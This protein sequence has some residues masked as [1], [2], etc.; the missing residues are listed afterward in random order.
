MSLTRCL[1][2]LAGLVLAG[3]GSAEQPLAPPPTVS[4]PPPVQQIPAQAARS[5]AAGANK[6]VAAAKS[7]PPARK[8][9][10]PG[11]SLVGGGEPNFWIIPRDERRDLL[12]M[13]TSPD[14]GVNA[15]LMTLEV[16]RPAPPATV[17]ALPA[18]FS[19]TPDSQFDTSGL[20]TRIRCEKDG[21]IMALVPGGLAVQ[22]AEGTP[23][24]SPRHPI[25]I[26]AF[27]MDIH[28]VTVERFQRFREATKG[29]K[30]PPAPPANASFPQQ[31]AV[32]VNWRDAMLYAKWTGRELP[33]ESEWE[34][35][36]R[37]V[38]GFNSPWGDD[39]AIWE[40]RRDPGQ[41]DDVGSFRT[42]VSPFGI[43][44]LAGNAR[45]WCHDFFA[46]DA[47]KQAPPPGSAAARNWPGPRTDKAGRRVV[48]GST[49]GWELW[50]REGLPMSERS[51]LIGF[52]CVLRAGG[53]GNGA[54]ASKQAGGQAGS[55]VAT[56][57]PASEAPPAAPT[58]KSAF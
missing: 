10:P 3:C 6:P 4:S 9:L 48:K 26:D 53:G 15:S 43:F 31:P 49:T 16:E 7:E 8:P 36:A 24:A 28:E 54:A 25:D 34:K 56:P 47:Y 58:K 32:G 21:A 13:V 46:E 45:E 38:N 5:V 14:P 51:P 33:T 18:G 20:P 41:I 12:A 1:G 55:P 37:G 57:V 52:R 30:T 17:P 2:L 23:T 35:A 44:D 29:D 40:R 27:Y 22:G 11:A 50:P 42:D 39:R 19:V